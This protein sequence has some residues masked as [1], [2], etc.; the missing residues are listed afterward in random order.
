MS[1][2]PP[3]SVYLCDSSVTF[4][5][6]WIVIAVESNVAGLTGSLNIKVRV[7]S[8]RF[9]INPVTHGG[10][11]SSMSSVTILPSSLLEVV[12]WFPALS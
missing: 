6:L 2:E 11:V 7:L 9:N 3:V 8:L 5:A 4:L 10:C 12:S 1:V